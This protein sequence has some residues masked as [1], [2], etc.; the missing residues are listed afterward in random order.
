M[1][2]LKPARCNKISYGSVKEAKAD[3]KI[4]NATGKFLKHSVAK[5]N[6]KKFVYQCKRCGKFHI[7]TLKPMKTRRRG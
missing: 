1:E 7:T 4:I 5:T 6:R 2:T 3:I